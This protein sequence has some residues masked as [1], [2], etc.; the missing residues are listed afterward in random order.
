METW[1]GQ[2]VSQPLVSPKFS[3]GIGLV[4]TGLPPEPTS[5]R[6]TLGLKSGRSVEKRVLHVYNGISLM[7]TISVF[8][9]KTESEHRFQSALFF[10]RNLHTADVTHP[11]CGR[12]RNAGQ[13]VSGYEYPV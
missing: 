4:L 12:S 5:S 7:Q 6:H 9:V 11:L 3:K 10:V 2:N 1:N 13:V 8:Q